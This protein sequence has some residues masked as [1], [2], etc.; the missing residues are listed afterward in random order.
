[1]ESKNHK[2]IH[3]FIDNNEVKEILQWVN[4]IK[5]TVTTDYHHMVEIGKVLKGSSHMY[6][7][8]KT[9]LTKKVTNKQSGNDVMN[10]NLPH[11]FLTVL[12]KI[13][14]SL[15]IPTDNVYLQIVDMN[16][17][18]VIKA[19]YDIGISGYINFKT[20]ISVLS[21]NYELNVGNDVF[22][23]KEKDLYCFEASLYKHWTEKEFKTRRVLLSY[24]FLVPYKILGRSENDPRVRLSN[25]IERYFQ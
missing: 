10:E 15:D 9:E 14:K 22:K 6:D 18:G 11:I 13:S 25:R 16:S 20:N 1:M 19:H 23:I 8:S 24:G 7:I 2:I 3:D 12:D 4:Q 21:E 5:H 17:G